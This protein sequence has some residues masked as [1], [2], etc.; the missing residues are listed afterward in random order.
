MYFLRHK[1][2]Y[3]RFGSFQQFLHW[4][5]C[6]ASLSRTS[7]T[8]M[9]KKRNLLLF[10][11]FI[12]ILLLL[13][14]F[15]SSNG[16]PIRSSK[17]SPR[18]LGRFSKPNKPLLKNLQKYKY[19]TRYVDQNLDHFSFADL[20]KF[21]QRYLIS[22][23]HWRGPDKAGPIFFYCGNEGYIDWFADNTGFVWEL[24]PR[25]GALVVFPEVN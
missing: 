18:F 14:Q 17:R 10:H 13:L 4:V 1:R 22:F 16:L 19:E 2:S 24:A 12:S 11:H 21:Q 3:F 5:H 9:A 7:H 6:A 15:S 8:T 23:E 20:P 25:F